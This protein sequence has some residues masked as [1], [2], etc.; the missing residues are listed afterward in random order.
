[1]ACEKAATASNGVSLLSIKV[2]AIQAESFAHVVMPLEIFNA[3]AE[4]SLEEAWA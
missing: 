3:A 4:R 2:A 1:V